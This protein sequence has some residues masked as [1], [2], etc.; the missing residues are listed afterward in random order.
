MKKRTSLIAHD[1]MIREMAAQGR[2]LS[3]IAKV[4][5]SVPGSVGTYLRKHNIPY[6]ADRSLWSRHGHPGVCEKNHET[7]KSMAEAGATLEAIAHAVGTS[8]HRVSKYLKRTG[9]ERAAW[10]APLPGKAR[11][12]DGHLNAAWKGGRTIDKDGYV[13]LWM[14]NH[15]EANRHGYVR[16][17]RIVMERILGRPMS[18][19]EVVHHKNDDRSDNRPENLQLFASN[20][21]HLSATLTG[22]FS[23]ESRS[24]PPSTR[25]KSRKGDP[26]SPETT[27]H[28]QESPD[29]GAPPP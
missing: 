23:R 9:I 12:T 21:E 16:E 28:S 19:G 6:E 13:L 14:P 7:V 24:L 18:R 26:P 25:K 1:E 20:A 29:T 11:R 4:T 3:E 5:G 22:Q 17:H 15:P 27:T 8:H 10:R 2:L